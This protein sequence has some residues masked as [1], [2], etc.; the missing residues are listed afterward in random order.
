MICLVINNTTNQVI[1]AIVA[2]LTDTPP[3]GCRLIELVQGMY[4]NGS[5]LSPIPDGMYWDGSQ[6]SQIPVEEITDGN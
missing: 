5:Q 3:A 1:N 4:W 6:L 2:E